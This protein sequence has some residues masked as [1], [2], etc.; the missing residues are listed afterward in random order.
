VHNVTGNDLVVNAGGTVVNVP[1]GTTL[2]VDA[3]EPIVTVL[4]EPSFA[5]TTSETGAVIKVQEP[6]PVVVA[7]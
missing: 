2:A 1:Q 3:G 7:S 5:A 6:A 4:K